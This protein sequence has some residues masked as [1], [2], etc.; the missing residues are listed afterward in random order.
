MIDIIVG[1]TATGKPLYEKWSGAAAT[2]KQCFSYGDTV[3]ANWLKSKLV[4]EGMNIPFIY[5]HMAIP[6]SPY[7]FVDEV[8]ESNY[9][10][11]LRTNRNEYPEKIREA[12][13]Q[14]IKEAKAQKSSYIK[15]GVNR[16]YT[17]KTDD[18]VYDDDQSKFGNS[19]AEEAQQI[20]AQEAQRVEAINN[21]L[22]DTPTMSVNTA[23]NLRL[24][25]AQI[26]AESRGV[27]D[28]DNIWYGFN[29][30]RNRAISAQIESRA[31]R[32]P[33]TNNNYYYDYS[34]MV[35]RPEGSRYTEPPNR[36]EE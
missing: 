2:S 14:K 17:T 31:E 9:N 28:P 30:H 4:D 16:Y 11:M 13:N 12:V 22:W 5:E 7:I 1:Y 18:A 34:S 33:T 6:V 36:E 32:E 29:T 35:V 20:I 19:T 25:T 8:T 27:R 21:S 23:N 24:R 26:A 3:Y 10:D 15:K